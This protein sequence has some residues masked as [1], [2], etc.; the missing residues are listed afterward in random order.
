M[1][2]RASVENEGTG[3]RQKSR[4]DLVGK[5]VVDGGLGDLG[6]PADDD[7]SVRDDINRE[8]RIHSQAIGGPAPRAQFGDIQRR[9]CILPAEHFIVGANTRERG[10]FDLPIA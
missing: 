4:D 5:E 7:W 10:V 3:V 9:R 2:D 8:F 1:L 6:I